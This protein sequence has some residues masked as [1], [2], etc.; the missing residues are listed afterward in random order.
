MQTLVVS[1]L[2]IV[3]GVVAVAGGLAWKGASLMVHE[4]VSPSTFDETGARLTKAAEGDGWKVLAVRKFHESIRQGAGIELRPVAVV[5]LC[6]PAR[7]GKIL[8][9]DTARSVAVFMPCTIA[10]YEKTDGK[11]YV[12]STNAGLLGRA[13]GVVVADVMGGPVA[14]VQER[15]VTAATAK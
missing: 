13:F 11:T 14:E 12:A 6:H 1:L 2:G 4:V 10:V 5:D 8:G 3:L 15:F 9:D 7:A